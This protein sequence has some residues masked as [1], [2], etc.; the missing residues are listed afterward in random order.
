MTQALL[1]ID[2]QHVFEAGEYRAHDIDGVIARLNFVAQA[3]RS[4]KQPVIY[5]QHASPDAPLQRGSEG[6]QLASGL[7]VQPGDLIVHKTASDAFHGTDLQALLQQHGVDRLIVGGAQSDYCVDS[8][9]RRALALG[10]PLQLLADGHT[11]LGNGVLSAEQI[12]A[13]HSRTLAGLESYG[14]RAEVVK[15]DQVRW[16]FDPSVPT[17]T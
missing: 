9:V 13:H 1:I 4:R 17:D 3:A 7:D 15:A 11:T 16:G 5:V 6:W 2:V 10:Y 14:P 8:T 12:I